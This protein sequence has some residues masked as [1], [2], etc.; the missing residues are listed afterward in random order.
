VPLEKGKVIHEP[1]EDIGHV[2]FPH[3]GMISVMALLSKGDMVETM[4][5]GREGAVGLNIGM[6]SSRA[7][8]LTVVQL[9]G[10]A[11]RVAV[12][13]RGQGPLVMVPGPLCS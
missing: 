7:L 5:I 10:C 4:T 2:Y 1:G 6:G 8:N 11:T 13:T 3:G 12:P 9:P